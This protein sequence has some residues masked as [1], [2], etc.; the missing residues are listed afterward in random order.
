[1]TNGQIQ[2]DLAT[3]YNTLL[4]AGIRVFAGTVTPMTG[5]SPTQ[6]QRLY[7]VNRWIRGYAAATSGV[8]LVDWF[9]RLVN[10][11]GYP[12]SDVL[13]DNVHPTTRAACIMG[14]VFA[15]VVNQVV[16]PL[17]LLPLPG[18]T[19]NVMPNPMKNDAGQG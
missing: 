7:D 4:R 15:D 8:H 11:S 18:D 12:A 19:A 16:P 17:D 3:I 9:S 13:T 5:L 2:N 1:R 10:S 14:S 6:T